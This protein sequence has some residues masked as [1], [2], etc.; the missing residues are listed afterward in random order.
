[1]PD[2]DKFHRVYIS[3]TKSCWCYGCKQHYCNSVTDILPPAPYDMILAETLFRVITP[4]ARIGLKTIQ[5]KENAYLHLKCSYLLKCCDTINP[6]DIA[7][8]QTSPLENTYIL[9][10]KDEFSFSM[11]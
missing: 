4:A 8:T 3:Q 10:L 11:D 2:D 6:E 1:M 7:I 5:E 9:K